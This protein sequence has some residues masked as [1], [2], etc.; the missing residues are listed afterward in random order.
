MAHVNTRKIAALKRYGP[1][2]SGSGTPDSHLCHP[3]MERMLDP[4]YLSDIQVSDAD[5]R[6][7]VDRIELAFTD[8]NIDDLLSDCRQSALNAIIVPLGLGKFISLYDKLG[9][10]VDTIH[11]ARN[12]VYA[13][14]EE[15][16][17]GDAVQGRN[18]ADPYD[19]TKAHSHP[20]YIRKGR[21]AKAKLRD[22]ELVDEYT[23]K[24]LNKDR[25][26]DHVVSAHEVY[27]DRG[28]VL[29]EKDGYDLAN[30][31]ANLKQTDP[32]L[33]KMKKDKT[34]TE[35]LGE[36]EKKK[37]EMRRRLDELTAKGELDEG[38]KNKKAALERKLTA[39]ENVD[40]EARRRMEEADKE[41][42]A[43]I[44][45][46]INR[47]YYTSGKFMKNTA[48]TSGAEGLKM[49]FQ[50]AFGLLCYDLMN[51]LF[52][53]VVD[54]WRN[55]LVDSE[56]SGWFEAVR[57]RLS[58]VAE[59]VASN[60]RS[61]LANSMDGFFSGLI[62]NL[63]TVL[64]NTFFTT[65][66][67]IVRMIREGTMVLYRAAKSLLFPD[68]GKNWR[69]ILD[70]AL[71]VI[72]AGAMGVGGIALE[73]VVASLFV[74]IPGAS[75]LT[76]ICVGLATGIL[77]ALAM[78]ALDRLDPFG[79]KDHKRREAFYAQI[80]EDEQRLLDFQRSLAQA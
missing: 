78:Y 75:I 57:K 32:C 27:E 24:P 43:A 22:Q 3:E 46:E 44:D 62:A 79:V 51:A 12:N 65:L 54:I 6:R 49:G 45:T 14:E 59:R 39:L 21:E 4:A 38:Q 35:F 8:R 7:Y 66:K 18:A 13:S 9:G 63:I 74:G 25:N 37:A 60:W 55:N 47:A 70:D 34:I 28:R 48:L 69:E 10:N 53:E 56:S 2:K 68:K 11:N 16:A 61:L 30:M 17:R 36:L 80:C 23:G 29:A 71:K 42:R 76:G 31:D 41:A 40:G 77:T 58:R 52:D 64:V 67:N 50:Q 5:V 15:R 73:E 72:V 26:Q 19:S 20:D 33:N 1:S